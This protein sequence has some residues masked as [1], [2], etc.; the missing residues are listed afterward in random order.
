MGLCQ[1]FKESSSAV[2]EAVVAW[3]IERWVMQYGCGL[4]AQGLVHVGY[5][6]FALHIQSHLSELYHQHCYTGNACFR[7]G[8][9]YFLFHILYNSGPY[10]AV[11]NTRHGRFVA[12]MIAPIPYIRGTRQN[13]LTIHF[14]I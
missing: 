12:S 10:P 8:S 3:W 2:E 6:I 1:A 14:C 9:M 7:Q 5:F 11:Y 13:N 4:G